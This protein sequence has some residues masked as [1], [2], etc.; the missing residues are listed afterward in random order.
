MNRD[1]I[2]EL[3]AGYALG[4]LEA[5][6]R[7]RFEA[8]LAA[9][10]AEAIAAL[11]DFEGA[12]TG[13]AE[14]TTEIPSPAVKAAL[15]ARI[16]AQG[17]SRE[18]VVRTLSSVKPDRPRRST[19]TLVLSG[20]MAAGIAAIAV[21]L[22][23]S[24]DYD[25]RLTQLAHEAAA[26][27][28]ETARQQSLL[29]LLRDPA[30]QVVALSGLEPARGAKA[31]MLWHATAGGLLVAQGLPPAPEGKAYELWAIAGT[32]APQPA[33]V[34]TVDARG[35]GSLRVAPIQAAG[36]VD[37]FAVTLEPAAGVPAPT[38][39]MYLAGKL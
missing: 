28:Q 16:D 9:G 5:E 39:A 18:A 35:V 12:V 31:R 4:A 15:M 7:A 38:G 19:W 1:E 37:T 34:F 6:D 32:G 17:R 22:V 14:E 8:L 11:R 29:A 27:K 36:T 30:T 13:L 2:A 20:A 25:Q 21:G 10:D 33:G 23:V 3:A 24:A 26:L